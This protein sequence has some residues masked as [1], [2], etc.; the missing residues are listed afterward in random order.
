MA[1]GRRRRG[2]SVPR[3]RSSRLHRTGPLDRLRSAPERQPSHAGRA[4]DAGCGVAPLSVACTQSARDGEGGRPRCG[5]GRVRHPGF[6]AA[7]G[8]DAALPGL[9]AAVVELEAGRELPAGGRQA[10]ARLPCAGGTSR[11]PFGETHPIA[12]PAARSERGP[13]REV[14]KARAC[15]GR[16]R[17]GTLA[18]FERRALARNGGPRR[19]QQC[20]QQQGGSHAQRDGTFRGER[21]RRH[22]PSDPRPRAARSL[23]AQPGCHPASLQCCR[24]PF[25]LPRSP[26]TRRTVERQLHRDRP[27]EPRVKAPA[28][29]RAGLVPPARIAPPFLPVM[30]EMRV[31]RAFC[32]IA[33]RQS[34]TFPAR[35]RSDQCI[36]L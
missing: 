17:T 15:P 7:V 29:T 22:R 21:S 5:D 6:E 30:A 23:R 10:E 35:A 28:F 27:A 2:T 11:Y 36:R 12:L 1:S 19:R 18:R 20:R 33:F 14:R 3:A 9:S 13:G 31:T 26:A 8:G 4:L 16:C 34:A 24:S 25:P 32:R